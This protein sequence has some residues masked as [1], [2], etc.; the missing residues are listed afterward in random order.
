MSAT[1]KKLQQTLKNPNFWSLEQAHARLLQ[2]PCTAPIYN[3]YKQVLKQD[4]NFK[5]IDFII[6]YPLNTK[7]LCMT[8]LCAG[9]LMDLQASTVWLDCLLEYQKQYQAREEKFMSSSQS[10][11]ASNRLS[12]SKKSDLYLPSWALDYI[13][14]TQTR[15]YLA[16]GQVEQAHMAVSPHWHHQMNTESTSKSQAIKQAQKAILSTLLGDKET[17]VSASQKLIECLLPV[18]SNH[19]HTRRK[20]RKSYSSQEKHQKKSQHWSLEPEGLFVVLLFYSWKLDQPAQQLFKELQPHIDPYLLACAPLSELVYTH[21]T[22]PQKNN[23]SY[24]QKNK[25]S[26]AK[27]HGASYSKPYNTQSYS[28]VSAYSTSHH[29]SHR[30]PPIDPTPDDP[31][32]LFAPMQES[33]TQS[34]ELIGTWSDLGHPFNLIWIAWC[35]RIQQLALD[36]KQI[37]T[38]QEHAQ[39]AQEAGYIWLYQ[40]YNA[41]VEDQ[42]QSFDLEVKIKSRIRGIVWGQQQWS[43]L[44]NH[45]EDNLN[46]WSVNHELERL[47][48]EISPLD[49]QFATLPVSSP[50]HPLRNKKRS[51]PKKIQ[52]VQKLKEEVSHQ[53]RMIWVLHHKQQNVR[54]KKSNKP[55]GEFVYTWSNLELT[56]RLQLKR[57]YTW[58]QGR[59]LKLSEVLLQKN[60]PAWIHILDYHIAETWQKIKDSLQA[61]HIDADLQNTL[62]LELLSLLQKHKHVY[63]LK[64]QSNPLSIQ[65]AHHHVMTHFVVSDISDEVSDIYWTFDLPSSHLADSQMLT[66]SQKYPTRS[67]ISSHSIPPK[68]KGYGK[69]PFITPANHHF[70]VVS[71]AEHDLLYF[72]ST[73]QET[74]KLFSTTFP[75]EITSTHISSPVNLAQ[76]PQWSHALAQGVTL[77]FPSPLQW[78]PPPSTLD[79]RQA[80]THFI[81]LCE[82]IPAPADPLSAQTD[83]DTFSFTLC[84]WLNEVDVSH[85]THECLVHSDSLLLPQKSRAK[86]SSAHTSSAQLNSS[87]QSIRGRAIK[88]AQ[89]NPI[90]LFRSFIRTQAQGY[91]DIWLERDMQHE[92]QVLQ[93]ILQSYP[94]LKH[95]LQNK[96]PNLAENLASD[97]A[98]KILEQQPYTLQL[99]LYQAL[100]VVHN[101]QVRD[102]A[103]GIPSTS[104]KLDIESPSSPPPIH[105]V[106]NESNPEHILSVSNRLDVQNLTVDIDSEATELS[107]QAHIN[108]TQGSH[109]I[110]L[111]L[112]QIQQQ[113][114][115]QQNQSHNLLDHPPPFLALG[116]GKFLTLTQQLRTHL[117]QLGRFQ[118]SAQEDLKEDSPYLGI[119]LS[120]LYQQHMNLPGADHWQKIW[121]ALRPQK[122]LHKKNSTPKYKVNPHLQATLRDYQQHGVDWLLQRMQQGVGCCLA[123]DMGLGKTLQ[124]LAMLLERCDQGPT[125]IVAPTS[126]C[127]VWLR[128]AQKFTPILDMI[129]FAESDRDEVVA[130]LRDRQTNTVSPSHS[131]KSS[132]QGNQCNQGNHVDQAHSNHLS[133][134][135][136]EKT[137]KNKKAKKRQKKWP[138]LVCSYGLITL[139][140]DLLKDIQWHTIIFDEAQALKNANTKR[141]GAILQLQAQSKLAITGTPIENHLK[142]IWSLFNILNP[143]LLGNRKRFHEKWNVPI[144]AG[145]QNVMQHLHLLLKPFI[146]RRNKQEVLHE[147]PPR[148]N[149]S[150]PIELG[151]EERAHYEALRLGSIQQAQQQ[152]KNNSIHILAQLTQLRRACCHPQLVSPELELPSAKM[153]AFQRLVIDLKAGGHRV[154]VFSQFVDYL[155]LIRA[156]LDQEN[157]HYQYLDGRTSTRMR[158]RAVQAFQNGEGDLFLISLK[159]GGFGLTLT[160]ADFVIHMDPWWNPAVEDQA[161]DRAHRIGQTKP[162]TVYRLV[163]MGTIEEKVMS[164]HQSKRH[165][166]QQLLS[167][168]VEKFLSKEDLMSLLGDA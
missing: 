55:L 112:E 164:L 128:E 96:Y 44:L 56:A 92:H 151:T 34:L 82:H 14:L 131:T 51:L 137:K 85:C 149:I 87:F 70:Y 166:A 98:Q 118:H 163:T 19:P 73:N 63:W 25:S 155:K 36:E 64:Y 86:R 83:Q 143:G 140:I 30:L 167:A 141:Y 114:V 124:A 16:L 150:V 18:Q 88:I 101:L 17:G 158:D 81:V 95:L 32:D 1:L 21:L 145:D 139:S 60:V 33:S 13:Q 162:V 38:L 127:S 40:Q 29:S 37:Q 115:Y 24:T 68:S 161:S 2:S 23:K 117:E 168:Q 7:I 108:H 28:S 27:T 122:K 157:W 125:L 136:D 154:L 93:E 99:E 129:R 78:Y 67:H 11:H 106:W 5:I 12:H 91:Q 69:P 61:D 120:D 65:Y 123:D 80:H 104:P 50:S 132:H 89:G 107:L 119:V 58:T 66:H 62:S 53:A 8:D 6:D 160:Q 103:N 46:E 9:S 165:L 134:R 84:V 74:N 22:T 45:D 79:L 41:L 26:Y 59:K 110:D 159:A 113:L 135:I 72:Y 39:K 133:E 126:L 47:D 144:E 3:L 146:L 152:T 148:T 4:S 153:I 109:K 15:V 111:S 20:A 121:R 52:Q 54:K 48:E 105:I 57:K 102:P 142:D 76:H 156:W 75:S 100:L 97:D 147:L 71:H 42:A 49:T 35:V 94:L 31:F 130:A 10:Q 138:I 116:D 90:T 77:E 43:N